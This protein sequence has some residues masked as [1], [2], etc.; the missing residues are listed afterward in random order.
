MEGT[1]RGVLEN[2]G[3]TLKN[4]IIDD[5][6]IGFCC[7]GVAPR[8]SET[9]SS[10]EDVH[11]W[12]ISANSLPI[13][14]N[15]I[16]RWGLSAPMGRH[17]LLSLREVSSGHVEIDGLD[18]VIWPPERVTK[19]IGEAVLSG[20]MKTN[21]A[22]EEDQKL[23]DLKDRKNAQDFPIMALRPRIEIENWLSQRG[24]DGE[25]YN[26]VFLEGKIWEVSGNLIG[27]NGQLEEGIWQLY[28]DPWTRTLSIL[29]QDDIS[30][31]PPNLRVIS[32]PSK[33]WLSQ[34]RL[35]EEASKLLEIRRKG[36]TEISDSSTVRSMLL[37]R[38]SLDSSGSTFV[39][40]R[41]FLPAWIVSNPVVSVLHARNGRTYEIQD[42]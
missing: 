20:D 9:G 12:I 26:P 35:S 6:I 39:E 3:V 7:L 2:R 5:E 22:H 42:L 28:E 21:P 16:I 38:W 41:L 33:N 31:K 27:P 14:E 40:Y 19:W 36:E 4:P 37:Q 11:V 23:P 1:I 10:E 13:S 32:P 15:E 25:Q 24:L 18:Y 17:W 8:I 34:S 29:E 30:E